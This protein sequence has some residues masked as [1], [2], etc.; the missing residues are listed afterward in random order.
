MVTIFSM[1]FLT[2]KYSQVK[3]MDYFDE[4]ELFM[5]QVVGAYR[6][7]NLLLGLVLKICPLPERS[8]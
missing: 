7:L 2:R 6:L 5:G 8:G 3:L 4:G 1:F